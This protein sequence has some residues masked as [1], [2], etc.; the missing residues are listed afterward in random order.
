MIRG[1]ANEMGRCFFF[2]LLIG[3]GLKM[4]RISNAWC[5]GYNVGSFW[6]MSFQNYKYTGPSTLAL[7]FGFFV[8]RK[9]LNELFGQPSSS[10]IS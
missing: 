6:K 1:V 8:L 10:G 3:S 9:C 2:F 7:L 4:E 5:G